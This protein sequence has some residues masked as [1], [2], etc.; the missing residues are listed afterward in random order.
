MFV[1]GLGKFFLVDEQ[2]NV[3][4]SDNAIREKYRVVVDIRASEI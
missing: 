2:E 4:V 1:N 3:F